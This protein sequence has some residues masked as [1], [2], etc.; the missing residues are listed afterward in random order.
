MRDVDSTPHRTGAWVFALLLASCAPA[1]QQQPREANTEVPK[2]FPKPSETES[3]A[4]VE[5]SDFFSDP[6]LTELIDT[7]LRNNQELNI[8]SLEIG[9][10]QNEVTAAT[11]EYLPRL[12]FRVG[13]GLEKVGEH[14]SQGVSD[15]AHDVPEHLQNY[16]FGFFASWEI[17]VWKK[18]RNATKAATLR[19]LASIEGKNFMVTRLVAEIANSYYEL[20]ALDNQLQV[21]EQNI[22]I[23]ENA[24]KVVKLQK[25]AAKVTE[26]AVQRFEAEVLKNQSKRYT[27]QQEI[28]ETENRI[29]FLVGRF[30]QPVARSTSEFVTMVPKAVQA[31]LPSQLLENRPDVKRASLELAA[32][33]LDVE[34]A[35]ARF[36]PSLEIHGGIGYQSYEIGK[37]IA[38]PQ[39]LLYD[40]AAH[41]VAPIFNRNALTAAYYSA[42]AQQ[43]QAVFEY[44]RTILSAYTEAANQ[45]SMIE[46]LKSSYELRS[47]EVAK[48]EQAVS[49]SSGL[50]RSARADYMEVLLTRRDALESKMEL[51]ET[52]KRQMSAVVQL[53]QALGGGWRTTQPTDASARAD[54]AETPPP[55]G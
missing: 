48:L 31:G 9:I 13:A 6:N 23:Q 30:P 32:A 36:Y 20:L 17:D 52:K 19:Y 3:S 53:Y 15:E 51:I 41:I 38:T 24:M 11:G 26:L 14:T 33:E 25:E 1:L 43:M 29:N 34:V 18:L 35:K 42:N 21:L 22:E 54:G 40:I 55:P 44:E 50:F 4:L 47:Q 7:A 28:I 2:A 10:A 8:V 49:T 5:W 27:I 45:I 12:D 46:N 39:S 37:L 16:T